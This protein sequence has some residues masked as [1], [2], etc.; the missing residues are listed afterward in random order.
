MSKI[1]EKQLEELKDYNTKLGEILSQIGILESNK[2]A[3]LH[4]IAGINKDIEDFKKGLEEEYGS[5]NI[6]MTS[7]EYT[8]VDLEDKQGDLS[9]V[10]AED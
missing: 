2:H 7:G 1:T 3:L 8:L 6:D 4:E 9:V 5:I 10:K